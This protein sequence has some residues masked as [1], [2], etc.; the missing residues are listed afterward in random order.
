M[1]ENLKPKACLIRL[2]GLLDQ[3]PDKN[4]EN[5]CKRF[6]GG[7]YKRDVG[8]TDD[9]SKKFLKDT[10]Y[11]DFRNIMF[12][13]AKD[14]HH[15]RYVTQINTTI[16]IKDFDSKSLQVYTVKVDYLV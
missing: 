4:F 7:I 6:E 3:V 10:L 9:A 12:S 14:T 5:Y 16:T 8:P 13:D 15:V 2:V 1:L 11:P